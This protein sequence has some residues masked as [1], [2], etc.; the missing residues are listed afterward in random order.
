MDANGHVEGA[1]P[2]LSLLLRQYWGSQSV[3]LGLPRSNLP[4]LPIA[5]FTWRGSKIASVSSHIS[6]LSLNYETSDRRKR[7]YS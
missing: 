2:K 1:T 3:R 6:I 4:Q 5:D 7:Q